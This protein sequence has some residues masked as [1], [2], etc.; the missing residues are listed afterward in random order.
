MTAKPILRL[1]GKGIRAMNPSVRTVRLASLLRWTVVAMHTALVV[2]TG[3][4]LATAGDSR[5]ERMA[6]RGLQMFVMLLDLPVTILRIP[7]FPVSTVDFA[8][9]SLA[10]HTIYVPLGGLQWYLIASLLAY[11][12]CGFQK[13]IPIASKRF[14]IA[15]MVGIL[16]VVGCCIIPWSGH[17]Q[18]VLYPRSAGIYA[19]PPVAFDGDSKGL[20]QTVIIPTLDTP[21]P[22]GKNVIWCATFQMAWDRLKKDVVGEPVQ[23]ANAEKVADRLNKTVVT[24][25]DLPKGS[26]YAAAGLTKDGIADKIRREMQERFQKEPSGLDDKDAV[27][28]AYAYLRASVPFTLPFFDNVQ[29]FQFTD[30]QGQKTSVS[31]FG[32]RVKDQSKYHD[33]RNQVDIIYLHREK[34]WDQPNEF[35]LDLCRD[36]NP[37]QIILACIPKK[38]TLSATLTYLEKKVAEGKPKEHE[39]RLGTNSTLLVPNLNWNISHHFAELEGA[40]KQLLNAKFKGLWIDTALQTIDFRLD[41]SGVELQSE[42]KLVVKAADP[43]F[44]FDRPFLIIVKKR[45]AERPFFVMWV[46]NAELLCK[47]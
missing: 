5:M 21:I 15:T 31:S 8:P 10:V 18:R 14:G 4:L 25:D 24:D 33:L 42:S 9:G 26:F 27:I 23:V 19:P 12:T 38:E 1:T 34:E 2:S 32:L 47:P 30:G 17:I 36:S 43:Q 16:L 44:R 13:T 6:N 29:E 35:A 22:E 45:G 7:F 37:N 46:D 3:I 41:R 39:R 40:G 11:W 28:L 20:R